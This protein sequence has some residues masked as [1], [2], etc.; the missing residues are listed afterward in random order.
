MCYGALQCVDDIFLNSNRFTCFF[1]ACCRVLQCIAVLQCVA[2]CC[3]VL[4]S[5]VNTSKGVGKAV[6]H[7]SAFPAIYVV[8][9][10]VYCRCA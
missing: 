7:D 3:G 4:Q 5:V 6:E 2:V 8:N 1:V 9:T 10:R